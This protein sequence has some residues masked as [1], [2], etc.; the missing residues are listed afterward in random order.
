MH[1]HHREP[2]NRAD[3]GNY[4]RDLAV[5][6]AETRGSPA[7]SAA[8]DRGHGAGVRSGRSGSVPQ[9][10][11]LSSLGV[12]GMSQLSPWATHTGNTAGIHNNNNNNNSSSSNSSTAYGTPGAT[13]P[14][15]TGGMA[16]SFYD[17]SSENV[18]VASQLSPAFRTNSLTLSRYHSNPAQTPTGSIHNGGLESPDAPYFNDDRRPSVASIATTASSQGSRAS[19]RRGGLRKL[20]GFFG[21]EFPGRDDASISTAGGGKDSRSHSYSH[22]RPHRD[23]NHSNA[24]DRDASPSSSRPRTPVPAPEVV[25]FLYQEVDV[26]FV[27]VFLSFFFAPIFFFSIFTV[28]FLSLLPSIASFILL[29]STCFYS[30]SCICIFVPGFFQ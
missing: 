22:G 16:T 3:F 29:V 4:R 28:H 19:D 15:I 21:E 12:T 10:P 9:I 6:D 2:H 26:S 30:Y 17:D 24:T 27:L 25:P 14:S 18:S 23:R 5:L 13:T 7:G 8:D 1:A 11:Q 20:Q